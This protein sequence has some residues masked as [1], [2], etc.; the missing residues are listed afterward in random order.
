MLKEIN[1][2]SVLILFVR[3]CVFPKLARKC[4]FVFVFN[5]IFLIQPGFKIGFFNYKLVEWVTKPLQT[6]LI[7]Q[8]IGLFGIVKKV[9]RCTPVIKKWANIQV[10]FSSL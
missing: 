9:I 3:D 7:F 2:M 6:I 5:L 8:G 10:I 1:L 4:F